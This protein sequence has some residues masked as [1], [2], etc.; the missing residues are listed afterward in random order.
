MNSSNFDIQE[1]L[2]RIV[3]YLIEGFVVA[4]VAFLLPSNPL[5][6][7]E[8]LLLAVTAAAVFALLDVIAPSISSTVRGGVGYGIG[9]KLAGFP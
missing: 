4:L 8:I 2:T 1:T 7:E 6:K 9:F 5:K 3:K